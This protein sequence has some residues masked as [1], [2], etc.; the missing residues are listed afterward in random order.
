MN[1]KLDPILDKTNVINFMTK[2]GL[3]LGMLMNTTTGVVRFDLGPLLLGQTSLSAYHLLTIGPR[4]LQCETNL[5]EIMDLES[6]D[7][8]K[9]DLVPFKVK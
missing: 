5:M 8:V 1:I 2:I 9:V 6:L 4:S 7:V 3:R